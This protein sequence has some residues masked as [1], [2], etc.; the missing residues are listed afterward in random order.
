VLAAA[1]R[2]IA[3]RDAHAW[4]A[5]ARASAAMFAA[6]GT[7]LLGEP[8]V[9]EVE[10][11][12]SAPSSRVLALAAG[13]EANQQHP[14][15]VAIRRAAEHRAVA[16]DAV[17]SPNPLPG[18]GVTAVTSAGEALLF[19]SRALMLEQRIS[20]ALAEERVT[21]LEGLGRTVLLV[22]AG[23][24]L[25]G[26]VALQ[27]GLRHGA[28]AAVQHLLDVEVEPVLLSGDARETCETIARALDIDHVRPEVLPADRA[29]EVRRLAE[30]GARVAV[31]G[32]PDADASVLSVAEVAIAL[33]AA[34]TAP[35][36]W[37]VTLAG[38]DVR[39]AALAIAIAHRTSAEAKTALVLAVAPGIIGALVVA[40]GLL[41]P[42][43]APL[44]GFVGG[45][46]TLVHARGV[47]TARRE[48]PLTA[49][50]LTPPE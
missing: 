37:A 47:M 11:T 16:P 14:S 3:Y 26:L 40:F 25:V 19:G 34:G 17:R 7:L 30:G 20:I 35:N 5:A 50:D 21:E 12:G 24:K 18:L 27:D 48:A 8:D 36:E 22:A 1:R 46:V 38:D 4:D 43:F 2:G 23:G 33:G 44:A 32:R 31:I 41:P 39:D 15:A 6:R 42:V 29:G 13:A 10:S 45:F 49:W 28:R 9:I